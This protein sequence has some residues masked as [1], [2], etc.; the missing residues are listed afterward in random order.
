[1]TTLRLMAIDAICQRGSIRDSD[2]ATLR[3]AFAL[4]TQLGAGDIEALFRA[5]NLA[6]VK[7]P[8]WADFF[9]E[10]LTDYVVRELEPSGYVTASHAGWL[11]A[12]VTSAGRIRSKSEHDL[13][14]NVIDK[15]R[16]IPE[17]LM[18]FALGQIRDAVVTGEGPLRAA[19]GIGAGAITLAEVE[20]IRAL[21]F[22]YGNEGPRAITQSEIDILLDIEA[23][24]AAHL[25][26]GGTE[27]QT[28]Q[29]EAWPIEAWRDLIEKTTA[30][31]ALA[32]SGYAGPSR[33]EAL[34]EAR[35]LF[36]PGGPIATSGVSAGAFTSEPLRSGRVSLAA[37]AQ[38]GLVSHYRPLP[39]E[40]RAM[41]RLELQRIEIITGEAV[42]I[43]DAARLAAR[44]VDAQLCKGP[45]ARVVQA[46]AA[47]NF[48]LAPALTPALAEDNRRSAFHAA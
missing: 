13:I 18:V 20:Q 17:S 22:A 27:S 1:M 10:T 29:I 6:R 32:T 21:L 36:N 9:I 41:L 39:I 24:V 45:A 40:A 28:S 34:N 2:V 47:A 4:E 8:C 33:E 31:A 48:A 23:A 46:L 7:D 14:L 26:S 44:L 43:A 11:I 38:G 3:R 15:A 5:H 30:S 12:R 25:S 19:S 37:A 42:A 35:P 16:W